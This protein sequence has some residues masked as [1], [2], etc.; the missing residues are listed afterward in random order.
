MTNKLIAAKLVS[1]L[2]VAVSLSSFAG[3][4]KTPGQ[5]LG[6]AAQGGFAVAATSPE[7]TMAPALDPDIYHHVRQVTWVVSDIDKIVGY[8]QRL[9]IKEG[10]RDFGSSLRS[11]WERLSWGNR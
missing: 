7:Q 11:V 10:M 2:I 9:G 4:L 6:A 5:L 3:N 1:G 8:W